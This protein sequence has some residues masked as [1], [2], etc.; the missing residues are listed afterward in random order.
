MVCIQRGLVALALAVVA[1]ACGGANDGPETG[2][3][4]QARG[5]AAR[6]RDPQ[7][8]DA[9]VLE[10]HPRR[11]DQGAARA[12]GAGRA[13]RDH[14]EGP[15]REDDR[16]QQIQ[17]VEG[18]LSQGVNGIVLAPLDASALVRPGARR[19]KQAGIPTVIID[20]ALAS[21]RRP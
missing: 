9:R 20:S 11:R 2:K 6:R 21:R 4:L 10:E 13:G 17:V 18:F 14:L 12:R 7:G 16:E 1:T 19:R 8:H 15:L 3:E 5:G